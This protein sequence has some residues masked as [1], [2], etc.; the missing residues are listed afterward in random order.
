MVKSTSARSR[1]SIRTTCE[2]SRS[3][4]SSPA[5]A[6]GPTHSGSRGGPTTA[7][8]GR[9]PVRANLSARQAKALGLMTSGTYGQPS[10]ISSAS[11]ALTSFLASRLRAR[12]DLLGSTLFKLTWKE[13]LTPS[14]RPIPALRASVLRTSGSAS[15][16]PESETVWPWATPAARDWKGATHDRW[17]TNARPL[18]EQ[19]KLTAWDAPPSSFSQ[20]VSAW[21][22]PTANSTTGAGTSGRDG[23]LNIQTAA[24]LA[25]W[26]TP[27]TPSGGQTTPEGTSA[28]GMTPDGKKVQVTLQ[29]VA[30]QAGWPTPRAA[31][32]EKNVRTLEGSLSEIERKGSPQD[33]AR[34]SAIAIGPARLTASGELLIGSSAGTDGGGQLNPA[35]SR[36]LMGLPPEW[37]ACAGTGTRSTPRKPKASSKP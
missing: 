18:N 27:T 25:A 8:S 23:G 36:W 20:T 32:G 24:Q 17:G 15:T 2:G 31:D 5:S 30:D 37:D 35:H 13:R 10:S 22:T 21:P 26:P 29:L 19:A 6:G 4:T 16:G 9:A 14:G 3:A 33:L 1:T 34:A 28:S 7:R 11:A 12:T